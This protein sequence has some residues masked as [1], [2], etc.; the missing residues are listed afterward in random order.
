MLCLWKL[1]FL[2]WNWTW[3]FLSETETCSFFSEN[4]I[5]CTF[6]LLWNYIFLSAK[7]RS[8]EF[9]K[10][11]M[12][13]Y[14]KSEIQKTF[15]SESTLKIHNTKHNSQPANTDNPKLLL[16]IHNLPDYW[17]GGGAVPS[18]SSAADSRPVR[19]YERRGRWWRGSVIGPTAFLLLQLGSVDEDSTGSL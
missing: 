3:S 2:I 17:A 5:V 8:L 4:H 6:I 10:Y 16:T 12:C 18:Y 9:I 15:I 19:R 1:Q 11:F 14:C 7:N 13:S